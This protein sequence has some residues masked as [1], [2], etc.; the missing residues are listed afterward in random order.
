MRLLVCFLIYTN[1]SDTLSYSLDTGHKTRWTII[2]YFRRRKLMLQK[3]RADEKLKSIKRQC[4]NCVEKKQASLHYSV[5]LHT[6][7]S[8]SLKFYIVLYNWS[9]LNQHHQIWQNQLISI[10]NA[11]KENLFAYKT[12][13][14][15]NTRLVS[16]TWFITHTIVYD[17]FK[18]RYN[19]F[20][21]N[22]DRECSCQPLQDALR[23]LFF[24]WYFYL[25]T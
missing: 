8:Y 12:Q 17:I 1:H 6:I 21:Y 5:F 22:T 9:L 10:L 24:Y 15:L 16:L 7:P 19:I 23:S 25:T 11:H 2:V 3:L 13:L 20:V 14:N 4:L 18:I